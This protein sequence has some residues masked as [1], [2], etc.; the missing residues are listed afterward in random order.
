MHA[1][2]KT[3]EISCLTLTFL[4]KY[5]TTSTTSTTTSTT[6]TTTTTT[7]TYVLS[8]DILCKTL[9]QLIYEILFGNGESL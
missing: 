5:H 8:N 1:A 9:I 6:T 4:L 2:G 7:A 3:R